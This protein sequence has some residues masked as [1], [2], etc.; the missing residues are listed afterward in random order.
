[1]C[2]PLAGLAI[3][4]MGAGVSAFSSY[5]ETQANNTAAEY[6]ARMLD[7]NASIATAQASDATRRGQADQEALRRKVNLLKGAQRA[8]Y[9][10]SGVLVDTDSALDVAAD[11]ESQ[12][13]FDSLN[14]SHNAEM[15]RWGYA[16]QAAEYTGQAGLTRMT[17]RSAAGAAASS[18]L[19]SGSQLA[20]SYF[21]NRPKKTPFDP[22]KGL[23]K[24]EVGRY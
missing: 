18:L 2:T 17:K 5:R 6:N 20:S 1:M 3:G 9:A 23:L 10:G 19:G 13:M 22:T 24:D 14:I 4:A 12:A 11:T 16:S 21:V 15:E 8:S 7:R